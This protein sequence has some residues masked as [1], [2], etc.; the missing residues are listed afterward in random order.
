[1]CV[2]KSRNISLRVSMSLPNDESNHKLKILSLCPQLSDIA[3]PNT[4]LPYNIVWWQTYISRM[5]S[6]I[7]SWK[8]I[9]V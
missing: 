8:V 1:M 3:V 2:E 6:R 5:S 9:N 7:F 4:I